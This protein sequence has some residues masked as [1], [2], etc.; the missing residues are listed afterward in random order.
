MLRDFLRREFVRT[1]VQANDWEDAIHQG[2]LPLYHAELV[3]GS[4][5]RAIVE[6]LKTLGPY[7]VISP[8]IVLSHA[9]PED[10]V[11]GAGISVINLKR[12]ISFG[13]SLNDPV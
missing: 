4:Y 3:A 9:A 2:V 1:K 13:H 12:P 11:S 5:E 7:M 6:K 8:G 10:G